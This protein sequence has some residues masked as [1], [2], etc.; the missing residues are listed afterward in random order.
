MYDIRVRAPPY[1]RVSVCLD[2]DDV[3]C[4]RHGK[5]GFRWQRTRGRVRMVC[6]GAAGAGRV[7]GGERA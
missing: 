5:R 1:L 6:R 2:D 7:A 4:D 3:R